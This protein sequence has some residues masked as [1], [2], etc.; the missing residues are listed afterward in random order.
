MGNRYTPLTELPATSN[1]KKD[2][3]LVL[4]GELFN[5][6]YANG[7][8]EAAEKIG[9][10]V[11]YSTVGRREHGQL[12]KLNAEEIN[13]AYQNFI[14]VPL[15]AGFDLDPSANGISPVDQLKDVKLSEWQN[16]KLD[17]SQIEESK[18]AGLARFKKNL[19]EWVEQLASKIP[20]GSNVVFA[21][22]MAGG[23]PRAKIVMP[24]M[25]RAFKGSGDRYLSSEEFWHSEIGKLCQDSF[26]SVTAS[27]FDLLIEATE[28]IRQNLAKQNLKCSYTAY[29]YHGTGILFDKEY[30]WQT[31]TPYLQG[32]AKK[33]LEDFSEKHWQN[34]VQCCVYNCPEILTNSSSI[35]QG[36]EVPLY[37]LMSALAKEAAESSIANSVLETCKAKLKPE[38]SI[39][40]VL[41]V[42]QDFLT[43]P[44][45]A[46]FNQ[47]D[48]WPQHSSKEQMEAL[49][50]CSSKLY[51]MH[52]SEKDLMTAPLSE[53]VF[54]ACGAIMLHDS[55]SAKQSYAWI[56]HDLVAK[57]FAKVS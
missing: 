4:F 56:N 10:K 29:G 45:F 51:E 12:R 33:A 49:L 8:V 6:G 16:C 31:Y 9:M 28:G 54:E 42:T 24:L 57:F 53:I 32:W 22:L 38:H 2:D 1:Y 43:S 3:V 23:V 13:P 48:R 5:R 15:E 19:N 17:W 41:K 20:S 37:P 30:K 18:K 47:F 27:T 14:N 46:K 21:H 50:N 39:A 40:D 25:N 44:L 55:F 11:I 35:F 7:L 52:L 26:M 34:K 36:V